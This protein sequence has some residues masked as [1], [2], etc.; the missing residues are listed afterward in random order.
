MSSNKNSM[1]SDYRVSR[2]TEMWAQGIRA[3]EIARQLNCTRNAA[4]GKAN[5]LGL[6]LHVLWRGGG[7][8][9]HEPRIEPAWWSQIGAGG[10]AYDL[11]S[12]KGFQFCGAELKAESSFCPT[13]HAVVWYA[14][15]TKR[16]A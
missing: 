12:D 15:P 11:G 10:C 2:L 16:A 5:R 13:H 1:W 6:G 3:A 14:A 8:R 4:I 7:W 9:K